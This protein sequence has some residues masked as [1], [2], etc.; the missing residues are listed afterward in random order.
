MNFGV[1]TYTI[2]KQQK[3]NLEKAYLPLIEMGILDYEIA[4]IHFDEKSGKAVR[5]LMDQYGIRI[6]AIQ[7]KPKQVFGDVQ[8]V[9][10]FCKC[11]G[12]KNVVLSMLPFSCI[13]GGE[14][15][16]YDFLN[17]LD[18]QCDVYKAHGITLAYHHHNWEYITLSSGKTRMEEL[19]EKTRKVKFVH[20]TYWT[21]KCG[22]SSARQVQRFGDRLL[23]IHLRD[24]T[25][26]KK[27]LK[28]LSADGAVGTG[29][30]D[31]AAVLQAVKE[32]A[33]Q[34]LVIEQKT[35]KPYEDLKTSY[36]NCLKIQSTLEVRTDER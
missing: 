6:S 19:L 21:T 17:R 30:V 12:C 35:E 14:G 15:K 34:Y 18:A 2:R 33:C 31:F 10:D 25:L 32:T 11:T 36:Q 4:R 20:D 28:V 27:G 9:L 3:K 1:Q 26:H 7:V 5:A 23:G 13:L 16:F 22:L 29:V 24:L 8:S